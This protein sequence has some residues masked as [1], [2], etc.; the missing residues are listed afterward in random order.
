MV[1][2]F[3]RSWENAL[4]FFNS[5]TTINAV[6]NWIYEIVDIKWLTR[7][8]KTKLDSLW[9]KYNEEKVNGLCE[10]MAKVLRWARY[11]TEVPGDGNVLSHSLW[12][13]DLI[14]KYWGNDLESMDL[15]ITKNDIN[16][17]LL[18]ALFHDV[19]E[20][21]KWDTT[22]DHKWASAEEEQKAWI[23]ILSNVFEWDNLDRVLAAYNIDFD[24]SNKLHPLFKIYEKF[25]Y[26]NWAISAFNAR[27]QESNKDQAIW[28]AH[29]VLKNQVMP[30]LS[31]YFVWRHQSVI[32]FITDYME[33]INKMASS[34]KDAWFKD[35]EWAENDEKFQEALQIAKS[36]KALFEI[37]N[38]IEVKRN[39]GLTPWFKDYAKPIIIEYLPSLLGLLDN[40]DF[41]PMREYIASIKRDMISIFSSFQFWDDD[42]DDTTRDVELRPLYKLWSEKTANTEA[43]NYIA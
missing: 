25:S 30:L 5:W 38:M 11:N 18:S 12:Q 27:W 39:I 3:V 16:V 26:I 20:I 36:Y 22:H 42:E 41:I 34:I 23:A 4:P 28:L 21:E 31:L 19:W 29:N 8:F 7:D 9:I 6:W 15:W 40:A 24:K 14:N 33:T 2:K 13:Y 32:D 17:L 1:N 35:P 43:V 10:K 37:N